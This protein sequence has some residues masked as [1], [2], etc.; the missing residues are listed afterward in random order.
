MSTNEGQ[1]SWNL[2]AVVSKKE[3][4]QAGTYLLVASSFEPGVLADFQIN[5]FS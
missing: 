1:Y 4:I 2:S 3:K 5:F